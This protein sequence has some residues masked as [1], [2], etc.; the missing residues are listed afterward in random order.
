MTVAKFAPLTPNLNPS[1]DA[2]FGKYRNPSLFDEPD[3]SFNRKFSVIVP[4]SNPV[5]R[6]K[7]TNAAEDNHSS[8]EIVNGCSKTNK[9]QISIVYILVIEMIIINLY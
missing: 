6:T 1:V 4:T 8:K 7:N 2:E 3:A 9:L 5:L